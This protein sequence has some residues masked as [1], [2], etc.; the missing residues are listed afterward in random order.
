[1]F[2]TAIECSVFRGRQPTPLA[3]VPLAPNSTPPV[4]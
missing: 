4:N 2:K 3:D 1:M